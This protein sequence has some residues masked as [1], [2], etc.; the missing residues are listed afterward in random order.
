MIAALVIGLVM[1]IPMAQSNPAITSAMGMMG[2]VVIKH[3]DSEGN[4][5]SYQQT[6]N[7]IA[8]GGMDEFKDANF[9]GAANNFNKMRIGSSNAGLLESHTGLQAKINERQSTTTPTTTNAISGGTGSLITLRATFTI[10]GADSGVSV[11]EA[12]LFDDAT[13]L[14]LSRVLMPNPFT[15]FPDDQVELDYTIIVG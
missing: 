3:L 4:I 1:A 10:T 15:V 5:L 2:H 11:E 13:D 12:G 14:M 6:D 9:G 8:I 7:T